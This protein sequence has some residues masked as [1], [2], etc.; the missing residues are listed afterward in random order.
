M[1][2]ANTEEHLELDSD[3][4]LTETQ[5]EMTKSLVRCLFGGITSAGSSFC[6]EKQPYISDCNLTFMI[7]VE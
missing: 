4:H 6:A 3:L 7:V 2:E 1:R 5:K